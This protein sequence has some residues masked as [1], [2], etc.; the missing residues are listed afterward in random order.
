MAS[1]N[2][3]CL[4]GLLVLAIYLPQSKCFKLPFSP[5]E[6]NEETLEEYIDKGFAAAEAAAETR[7]EKATKLVKKQQYSKTLAQVGEKL[8]EAERVEKLRKQ[9]EEDKSTMLAEHKQ[10][11]ARYKKMEA[12]YK[13][14]EKERPS[15]IA[16]VDEDIAR[17]A[18][19]LIEVRE[20]L[21]ELAAE[22]EYR[23]LE[24]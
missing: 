15:K 17:Y 23:K 2:L 9:R 14:M 21:Q 7:A 13:K 5:E 18:D 12:R 4:L 3:W 16:E 19:E 20:R 8:A 10:R 24:L 6:L 11:E 22:L 1:F